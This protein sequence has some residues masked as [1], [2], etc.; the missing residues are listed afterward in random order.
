M[1]IITGSTISDNTSGTG[2]NAGNGSAATDAAGT[3]G[4]AGLP[5]YAGDG[6]GI[7]SDDGAMTATIAAATSL[8]RQTAVRLHPRI[9]G[10]K[11]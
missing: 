9:I 10:P 7:Y 2:G 5:G 11:P 6:G 8:R 1:L 3:G 4:D